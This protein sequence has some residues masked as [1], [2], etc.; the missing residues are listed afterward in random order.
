MEPYLPLIKSTLSEWYLFTLDNALYA[1][2]LAAAVWLLSAILYNIK[3]ASLKRA[4]ATSEKTASENINAMQQQLQQSQEHLV[5]TVEEKEQAQSAIDKETQRALALEQLIYQRNQQIANTIQTLSG[6]FDLGERPLLASE[7]VKAEA[8]W[9]QHDKAIT[10]LIERLRTESKA[11]IESQQACQIE[12]A[13][14]AEKEALLK[15]LQATLDTHTHQL[16]NLEQAL[17]EQ[18]NL[19]LEQRIADTVASAHQPEA[20]QNT[21]IEPPQQPAPVITD[22]PVIDAPLMT[23]SEQIADVINPTMAASWL[24]EQTPIEPI[25]AVETA[26][27][28]FAE[29]SVEPELADESASPPPL[30]E[31]PQPAA[32]AKGSLGKIKKLFGKKQ[33]PVKT[34]PQ[35][36]SE[37]TLSPAS[38]QPT[39]AAENKPG[40]MK[41]FYSKLRSKK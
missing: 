28:V 24:P 2:V 30:D 27:P 8:L 35:W 7:D 38:E 16:S 12:T 13:K 5:A 19:L 26:E 11:K 39:A 6:S 29:P 4:K 10:Q 41:G 22:N 37:E 17:Q 1:T 14:L 18:K 31:Q 3:I 34:E 25:I 40:K 21:D 9:Q 36:T 23:N 20:P 32:E 33:V 15:L